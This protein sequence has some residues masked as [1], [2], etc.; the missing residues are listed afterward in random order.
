MSNSS[1]N[2]AE[3]K[4]SVGKARGFSSQG[5]D[6]SC[7]CSSLTWEG[8]ICGNLSSVVLRGQVPDRVGEG[9]MTGGP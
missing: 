9:T 6:P 1:K 3:P 5:N 7:L 8:S 4:F 2:I